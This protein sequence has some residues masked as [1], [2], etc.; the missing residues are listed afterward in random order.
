MPSSTTT[1][2]EN[3]EG[4]SSSS[5]SA[6]TEVVAKEAKIHEKELP[7]AISVEKL[8]IED[9]ES[10]NDARNAIEELALYLKPY[11]NG[12]NGTLLSRPMLRKLVTLVNCQLMEDEGRA[13]CLRAARSLGERTVTELILQHQNPQQLS[14]NLW[15]AVRARGCQFLGPAMQ[16]EVLK[17]VL[18]AL[19]D[20]SALSRKVLVMFVVQRLEPH[21][22]QA[23]KTSI[24]HV[25]QLLYRASCFKVSKREGDSSLMQLKEEYR[26]YEA[27]R[28]E[29]DA[30]IVQIATEAGL[31]IAPDQWSSLLYG[32]TAHK[33]HMQSIIDK[34]QTPQSF[35]QSVQELV[36]ALQ[37]TGDP[38]NLSGLRAHLKYLASIDATTEGTIPTWKDCATALDAVRSVVQGLVEFVQQHGNRKLQDAS[39]TLPNSKYKIS[40][41]RDLKLRGTCPRAGNCTFAHS[42]DELERY[43]AKVKKLPLRATASTPKETIEFLGDPIGRS[44]SFGE[45]RFA[46]NQAIYMHD[47]QTNASTINNHPPLLP[48]LSLPTNP[49]TA[50]QS[51]GPPP[52]ILPPQMGNR[53]PTFP[54]H[55]FNTN[56]NVQQRPP[57]LSPGNVM[58]MRN[59]RA[60]Y[61]PTNNNNNPISMYGKI[62]LKGTSP[63]APPQ[64]TSDFYNNLMQQQVLPPSA[65]TFSHTNPFVKQLQNAHEYPLDKLDQRKLELMRQII[66]WEQQQ[67]QQAQQAVTQSQIPN[68]TPVKSTQSL[69]MFPTSQS[70]LFNFSKTN[71]PLNMSLHLQNLASRRQEILRELETRKELFGEDSIHSRMAKLDLANQYINFSSIDQQNGN[72]Y[73]NPSKKNELLDFWGFSTNTTHQSLVN[74]PAYQIDT[75]ASTSINKD[76]FVRSD[77]ILDDD[78]IPFETTTS[79]SSNKF[80]PISR[81]PSNP[82]QPV[83]NSLSLCEISSHNKSNT[84]ESNNWLYSSSSSVSPNR[85]AQQFY[86]S[87][88]NLKDTIHT[89][90]PPTGTTSD[91]TLNITNNNHPKL[92][93]ACNAIYLKRL[94]DDKKLQLELSEVDRK[95]ARIRLQQQEQQK[96]QQQ[97][98]QKRK[99]T[100]LVGGLGSSDSHVCII[101]FILKTKK[102][103]VVPNFRVEKVS[104]LEISS[105]SQKAFQ[106][107]SSSIS[108]QILVEF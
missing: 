70:N 68:K 76:N 66:E 61:A 3:K 50:Y 91:L 99:L 92:I 8:N 19:E 97:I 40:F 104:V 55:N 2:T 82:K 11:L 42:E 33:S 60:A 26:T 16:E 98:P 72:I 22:H 74:S 54:E 1:T 59:Y 56:F 29:H 106:K 63:S 48:H 71:Q 81:M 96:H 101:Y 12:G 10:Y 15:A 102:I 44:G 23:S 103:V 89:M 77:S 31:R 75:T 93:D 88:T 37:R 65:T 53:F 58:N 28:R 41:C 100:R 43:R 9:L 17:L 95:I 83:S 14:T 67:Q 7:V 34:L 87:T 20:G 79:T 36:I 5:K 35:E 13:R 86:S 78:Y 46:K 38:A 73:S 4:A 32:D 18:L 47:K 57:P 45:E 108:F 80:G 105:K 85:I 62:P 94:S 52:N 25:V 51:Q 24:G 107:G 27:L 49:S 39:H 64:Y 30:Q 90:M 69:P 21:F 84:D 6:D